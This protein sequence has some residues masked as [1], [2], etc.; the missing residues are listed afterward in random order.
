MRVHQVEVSNV[1]ELDEDETEVFYGAFSAFKGCQRWVLR[2]DHID[3][4]YVVAANRK[5]SLIAEGAEGLNVDPLVER[6]KPPSEL[7][8]I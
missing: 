5:D 3:Q 1:H 7:H 2:I 4:D 8:F 6:V